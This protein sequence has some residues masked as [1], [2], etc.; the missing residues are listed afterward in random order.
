[1]QKQSI[2]QINQYQ[3]N[4]ITIYGVTL[5]LVSQAECPTR[6]LIK[7]QGRI[8]NIYLYSK[9]REVKRL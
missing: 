4:L 1:M 8:Y 7:V 6:S 9:T 3:I 5:T 2:Y